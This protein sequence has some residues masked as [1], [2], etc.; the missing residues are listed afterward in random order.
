MYNDVGGGVISKGRAQKP[1]SCTR[2]Y[3]HP[4]NFDTGSTV[5]EHLHLHQVVPP[6]QQQNVKHQCEQQS[7]RTDARLTQPVR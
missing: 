3:H 5:H 2:A 6:D 4:S 7:T 1:H